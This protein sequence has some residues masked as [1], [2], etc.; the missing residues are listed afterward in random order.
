MR[1]FPNQTDTDEMEIY[2]GC[3]CNHPSHV[4]KIS[5]YPDM[6]EDLWFSFINTPRTFTE[7]MKAIWNILFAGGDT[8]HEILLDRDTWHALAEKLATRAIQ[9]PKDED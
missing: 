7:K 1:F 3:C 9:N 2:V 6:D 4:I 8:V 5:H